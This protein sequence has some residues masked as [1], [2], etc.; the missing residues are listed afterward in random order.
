MDICLITVHSVKSYSENIL[1][2]Q[3][4]DRWTGFCP[5]NKFQVR[6]KCSLAL[7]TVSTELFILRKH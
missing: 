5:I 3:S 7:E 6:Q 2:C 4:P 1:N